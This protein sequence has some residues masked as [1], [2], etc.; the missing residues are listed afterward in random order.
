MA[1]INVNEQLLEAT[2][3]IS[4][5]GTAGTPASTMTLLNLQDVSITNNQGTFRY[6]TLDAQSE[7]VI[8]TVATN[9]VGLNCVLDT[10]QFFGT[11]T[12]S[13]AVL[14]KGLF[15]TSN[16]KTKIDFRIY[17]QGATGSGK[18]YV[19]GTGYITGLAPTVNPG[20]PLW[21]SPIT[22]EVDG[23]LGEDVTV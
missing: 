19:H 22:I 17:F 2:V 16:D 23:N 11:G 9:S 10:D 15:G 6:Q 14:E 3:E 21:V 5:L 13:S 8:T 4:D 12:G 7:A 18:K 1:I 20:A